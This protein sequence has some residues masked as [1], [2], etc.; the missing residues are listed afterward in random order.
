ML[1]V[2]ICPTCHTEIKLTESLAAPIVASVKKEYERKIAEK[3]LDVSGRAAALREQEK[4]VAAARDGRRSIH[5]CNRLRSCELN[6]KGQVDSHREGH[7]HNSLTR[8][9]GSYG[10]KPRWIVSRPRMGRASIC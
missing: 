3:D 1:E 4:E 6:N 5:G 9:A 8:P 2:I 10:E 7:E